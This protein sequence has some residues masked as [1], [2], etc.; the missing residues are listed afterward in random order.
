MLW[1]HREV[2]ILRERSEPSTEFFQE[3]RGMFTSTS[4]SAAIGL[5]LLIASAAL[6]GPEWVEI[7]DAGKLPGT[8]Q[9]TVGSTPLTSIRGNIGSQTLGGELD[10]QDMYIVYIE[11]PKSFIA[12]TVPLFG[13]DAEF[14]SQL[15]LLKLDGL[16]LLGNNDTLIIG[17]SGGIASGGISSGSTLLPAATDGTGVVITSP[18]LYLIA[19]YT[20]ATRP[21]SDDGNLFAMAFSTEISGP[22]GPGGES[23]ISDWEINPNGPDGPVGGEY[24]IFLGGIE[25]ITEVYADVKPGGCPNSFNR[26][27]NGV[28]PVAILG[29]PSFDVSDI[30]L[31]TVRISRAVGVQPG[32]APHEGPPGPHSTFG[33]TATPYTGPDGGCHELNGDGIVDLNLKFKSSDVTSVLNLNEFDAGALVQIKITGELE[34]GTPFTGYDWLRLVPPNTPPGLVAVTSTLN[35]GWIDAG[36]LDLALDGGGFANF[37]RTYPQTTVVTLMA[38]PVP[39]KV[40]LGW[41]INNSS[42]LVPG[43]TLIYTVADSTASIQAVYASHNTD[44]FNPRN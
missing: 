11:D 38:P 19:I 10:E 26:N 27:S 6:A 20:V 24:T 25:L 36:P 17:D 35:G 31:S 13:G 33:D 28:L 29:T 37:N 8:A 34:D 42:N 12:T 2:Q 15:C 40:F 5:S 21:I 32:V 39:N 14:D 9:D 30:N 4:G 16:G 44:L 41:K 43:T 1:L 22:D 23:P 18:G 3:D 7:G